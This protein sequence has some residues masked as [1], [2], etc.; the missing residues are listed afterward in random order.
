MIAD[1]IIIPTDSGSSFAVGTNKCAR[2]TM[3]ANSFKIA[4]QI[5]RR[6]CLC[7]ASCVSAGEEC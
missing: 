7:P 2:M 1:A 5:G 3:L 4:D 6:A